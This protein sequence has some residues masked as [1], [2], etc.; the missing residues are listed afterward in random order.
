MGLPGE[1]PNFFY[2]GIKGFENQDAIV[3]RDYSK[4]TD[5]L[6]QKYIPFPDVNP[7]SPNDSLIGAFGW[8]VAFPSW[9]DPNSP[10]IIHVDDIV[11]DTAAPPP[12]P[13]AGTP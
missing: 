4:I 11:W 9:A 5:Q 12:T 8:S 2:G 6:T 7:I 3:G 13:E 10:L 1:N